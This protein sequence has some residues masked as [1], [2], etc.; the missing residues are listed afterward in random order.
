MNTIHLTAKEV[1]KNDFKLVWIFNI[2]R[3]IVLFSQILP[4]SKIS[5]G[6]GIIFLFVQIK[7]VHLTV[8][9]KC[10]SLVLK[11]GHEC[12]FHET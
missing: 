3:S 2:T 6:I 10:K 1:P 4:L 11:H 9:K 5:N 8:I 7:M 12:L